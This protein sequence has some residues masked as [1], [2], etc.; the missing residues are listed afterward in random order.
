MADGSRYSLR[1]RGGPVSS[2]GD[3]SDD[4]LEQ[5]LED[6]EAA[7]IRERE[8]KRTKKRRV[9]TAEADAGGTQPVDPIPLDSLPSPCIETILG[10][11]GSARGIYNLAF[12]SKFVLG[13]LTTEHVI[14][15]AVFEVMPV[16]SLLCTHLHA[17]V[18]M[19]HAIR[20]LILCVCTRNV[21]HH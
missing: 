2:S 14:R 15:A 19:M 12:S 3:G 1:K 16:S 6:H 4:E 11:I 18:C 9:L 21:H 17:D 5:L 13:H 8:E 7:G 20:L 10:I